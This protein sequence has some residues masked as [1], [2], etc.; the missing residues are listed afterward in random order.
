MYSL[1]LRGAGFSRAGKQGFTDFQ[2]EDLVDD[3]EPVIEAVL[4]DANRRSK[5]NQ[6]AYIGHSLGAMIMYRYLELNPRSKVKTFIGLS[7]PTHIS[8]LA[9]PVITDFLKFSRFANRVD[10]K[11]AGQIFAPLAGILPSRYDDFLYNKH[12][13][14]RR[15][16]KILMAHGISNVAPSL[17]KQLL[18]TL[19]SRSNELEF[20]MTKVKVPTFLITG[21]Y[22]N[23]CT[24]LDL[25]LA[26]Q[27]LGVPPADKRLLLL[28]KLYGYRVDYCHGSIIM[29]KYAYDDV[30]PAILNWLKEYT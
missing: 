30:F 10:I 22:D 13:I 27:R 18:N 21:T 19:F 16:L 7:G 26:Y 12:A 23:L 14:D 20:D 1:D 29:G 11:K 28:G 5:Q 25:Q 6:V 4:K 8:S 24:P 17:S 15:A 9:H 3:I 2:F